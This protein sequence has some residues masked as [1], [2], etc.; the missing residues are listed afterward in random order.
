MASVVG[1]GASFSVLVT[2]QLLHLHP[3]DTRQPMN[4]DTVMDLSDRRL[5]LLTMLFPKSDY[6]SIATNHMPQLFFFQ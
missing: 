3:L 4:W 5:Q 6:D 2:L 1:G